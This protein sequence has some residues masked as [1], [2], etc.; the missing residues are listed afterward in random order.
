ML[1]RHK[2]ALWFH[3]GPDELIS[4]SKIHTLKATNAFM[5]EK[6]LLLLN[7]ILEISSVLGL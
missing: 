5:E 3:M 6:Q 1:L 7:C 4:W 2:L